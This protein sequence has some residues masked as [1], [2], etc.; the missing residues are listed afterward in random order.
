MPIE[1]LEFGLLNCKTCTPQK[2]PKGIMS[3][4]HKTGGVLITT[5]DDEE[6]RRLRGSA[7]DSVESL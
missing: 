7:D 4:S 3:Y 6:F 5:D 1:R 2:K